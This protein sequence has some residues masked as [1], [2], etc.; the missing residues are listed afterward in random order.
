MMP[1]RRLSL[2]HDFASALAEALE[3]DFPSYA[4]R[5]L[6]II[7]KSGALI[8]LRLN[9]AQ[10][11]IHA[12]IERQ[13]AE[14]GK[15]RTLILKGRQQGASTYVEGRFF[16]QLTRQRGQ[17]GF[18]L[19]HVDEATRRLFEMSKRFH[20]NLPEPVVRPTLRASNA[21]ELIFD[22]LD[23]GIV[24]STAGSRG[25]GRSE[26][27]NCFHGSEVAY[28]PA[29]EQHLSGALQAVPDS[30][31]SEIV[32]ESTSS[33]PVGV[34]YTMCTAA[35]R[36]EGDYQLIFVP[37]FLS[38]EYR[39]QPPPGFELTEEEREYQAAHSLD[40]PQMAWRRGKIRELFGIWNF[41]REYPATPDEAFRAEAP[42]A[43]WKRE[44]IEATRVREHPPLRRIVVGVDPS[45][46]GADEAGIVV[47]GIAADQHVY[48]LGDLSGKMSPSAWGHRVIAA[49]QRHQADRIVAEQNFGG[50][51]VEHT[52]RTFDHNVAIRVVSASR[53]K[54][55][56]AEPIASLYEQ[57]RVHHVGTF[58]ALED[59]LVTWDPS[60]TQRS[61]NRL[62]ALVWAVSDL[63][64]ALEPGSGICEYYEREAKQLERERLT[65]GV[66][67]P[68]PSLADGGVRLRVKPGVTIV[69]DKRGRSIPVDE[70]GCII[71]TRE[72]AQTLA[73]AG[74][75]EVTETEVS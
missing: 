24:V 23:S 65:A 19:T 9:A 50:A 13:L 36:G 31:G 30:G 21:R 10:R 38:P 52:I 51:M 57:G 73:R 3:D 59:E 54:Q 56:R 1:E 26:T 42:G 71:V 15:V 67:K 16:W 68:L 62:D 7:A 41:R 49:Y 22:N 48:V 46:G 37:W 58:A 6:R 17:R 72:H 61:P 45:G 11:V 69:T 27:I 43:L 66:P 33:G 39:R 4:E 53:G 5:H 44:V 34:F 2:C 18:I 32:L 29:A 20:D 64:P 74:F 75:H 40:L 8:P 47:A 60:K 25:A 63:V 14:A 12:A 35:L 28:W 55:I 70:D